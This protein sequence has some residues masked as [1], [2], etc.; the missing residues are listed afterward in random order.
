MVASL[1]LARM[2]GLRRGGQV[3]LARLSACP[4]AGLPASPP[5]DWSCGWELFVDANGDRQRNPGELLLQQV[6][7]RDGAGA[8]LGRCRR[9]RQRLGALG[10][11]GPGLRFAPASQQP[12]ASVLLCGSAGGRLRTQLAAS[13]CEAS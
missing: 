9:D 13:R 12:S 3:V 7:L 5:R 1:Q 10:R 2:E 4:C 8:A 6:L 11:R